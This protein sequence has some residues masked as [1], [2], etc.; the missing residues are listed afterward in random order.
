ML[1]ATGYAVLGIPQVHRQEATEKNPNGIPTVYYRVF[2]SRTGRGLGRIRYNY[3]KNYVETPDCI[4]TTFV[5]DN[6][7]VFCPSTSPDPQKSKVL[8]EDVLVLMSLAGK[9]DTLATFGEESLTLY[10]II[11]DY[12]SQIDREINSVA[13]EILKK[14]GFSENENGIFMYHP[15]SGESLTEYKLKRERELQNEQRQEVSRILANI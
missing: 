4:R 8:L 1:D 15:S 11:R 5:P 13:M 6:K 12:G 2:S 10:N 9:L 14:Y 7:F 3:A